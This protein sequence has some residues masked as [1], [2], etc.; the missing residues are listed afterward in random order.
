MFTWKQ[1]DDVNMPGQDLRSMHVDLTSTC[2]DACEHDINCA[3]FVILPPN[4]EQF[5]T[6]C[7][8][9]KNPLPTPFK[10][11]QDVTSFIK[12]GQD[13]S[14][15]CSTR[16]TTDGDFYTDFASPFVRREL[17]GSENSSTSAISGLL[18]KRFKDE[19]A[20]AYNEQAI[21][22][23]Q[24][25]TFLYRGVARFLTQERTTITYPRVANEIGT[26]TMQANVNGQIALTR[27]AAPRWA[28][29]EIT[30]R[31]LTTVRTMM[32]VTRPNPTQ[33]TNP[34]TAFLAAVVDNTPQAQALFPA[35]VRGL[36]TD[37]ENQIQGATVARTW[38]G[39]NINARASEY[40]APFDNV[41]VGFDR[42]LGYFQRGNAGPFGL[43]A[44]FLLA[45]Q[46][47]GVNWNEVHRVAAQRRPARRQTWFTG[48]IQPT[49]GPA[50]GECLTDQE[51]RQVGYTQL[52]PGAT[53]NAPRAGVYFA[54]DLDPDLGEDD[55]NHNV[56]LFVV[57][58]H[59]RS[60]IIHVPNAPDL[61]NIGLTR[62]DPEP[63]RETARFHLPG[64]VTNAEPGTLDNPVPGNL[65]TRPFAHAH[66]TMMNYREYTNW[67]T[68]GQTQTPRNFPGY[69]PFGFLH[70][71]I[72]S[73]D[74]DPVFDRLD[75]LSRQGHS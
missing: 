7:F 2:R 29:N 42:R 71:Y 61:N 33:P 9:K 36:L 15:A 23:A 27:T 73:E 3:A 63:T 67:V 45:A 53:N 54:L 35:T 64:R 66:A 14:A 48:V 51:N 38:T 26:R 4:G 10:V 31:L 37:N 69:T 74:S 8:L 47:A 41:Q 20:F 59:D 65:A 6:N 72:L 56:F 17:D 25:L 28:G 12:V 55:I 16:T 49:M 11:E 50:D 40:A 22:L 62:Y 5:Q 57:H 68:Q 75:Y 21:L 19:N 13:P 32:R 39:R 70:L 58:P 18:E 44:A 52:A 30:Y 43:E 34:I 1:L 60:S 46:V 24:F